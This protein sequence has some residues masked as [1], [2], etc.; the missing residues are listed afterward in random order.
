MVA[1]IPAHLL[2]CNA[3]RRPNRLA[4]PR[5]GPLGA[6]W[7]VGPVSVAEVVCRTS[8]SFHEGASTPEEIVNQA[9]SLGLSAVAITDRDGVYGIPRAHKAAKAAGVRILP[10]ALLTIRDGPGVALLSRE[11]L[12]AGLSSRG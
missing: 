3:R 6:A 10:G 9:A 5:T 7:L 2:A 8:F 4:L 1:P 11:T 12:G